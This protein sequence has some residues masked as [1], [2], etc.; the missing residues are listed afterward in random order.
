MGYINEAPLELERSNEKIIRRKSL[1]G[2]SFED[3]KTH[4]IIDILCKENK[5]SDNIK[6]QIIKICKTSYIN[7]SND[8]YDILVKNKQ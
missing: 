4:E 1:S 6:N 5:L 3:L 8:C 2:R 7:G